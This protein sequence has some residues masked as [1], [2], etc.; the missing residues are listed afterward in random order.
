MPF[1]NKETQ[2]GKGNK[3]AV[4]NGHPKGKPN[5]S[6]R[7][8][9]VCQYLRD[10]PDELGVELPEGIDPMD[11]IV[12]QQIKRAAMAMDLDSAKWIYERDEGKPKQAIDHTTNGEN[13]NTKPEIVVVDQKTKDNINKLNEMQ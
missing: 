7:L 4:G 3:A 10:H 2:F 12:M 5:F 1:P 11:L 8:K 9:K 6:T 13:L